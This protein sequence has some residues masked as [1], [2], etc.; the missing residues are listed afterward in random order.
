MM[1]ME[2]RSLF[3]ILSCSGYAPAGV[4]SRIS[5]V[6]RNVRIVG[7]DQIAIR[8]QLGDYRFFNA[9]LPKTFDAVLPQ[10]RRRHPG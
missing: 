4:G 5:A 2:R 9:K 3:K 6:T 7:L 8:Q 1:I 10:C